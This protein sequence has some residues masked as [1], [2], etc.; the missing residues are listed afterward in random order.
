MLTGT[1]HLTSAQWTR[2]TNE[3]DML[4]IDISPSLPVHAEI[5][6]LRT[7]VQRAYSDARRSRQLRNE[8]EKR[9]AAHG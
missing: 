9:R 5:V 1:L 3:L 4:L 7:A 8:I 2:L 6:Q